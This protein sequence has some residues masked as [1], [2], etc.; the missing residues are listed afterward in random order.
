MAGREG[1]KTQEPE[2][3]AKLKGPTTPQRRLSEQG[4]KDRWKTTRRRMA[5]HRMKH[6]V[7]Q[8]SVRADEEMEA[9]VPR[10]SQDRKNVTKRRRSEQGTEPISEAPACNKAA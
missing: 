7:A 4:F 1:W 5:Q 9:E 8:H 2:E 6:S 3:S 10:S